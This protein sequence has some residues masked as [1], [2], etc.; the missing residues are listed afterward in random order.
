MSRKAAAAEEQQKQ[1]VLEAKRKREQAFQ[2][3]KVG[4]RQRSGR[5]DADA[6]CL[7]CCCC[8][9]CPVPGAVTC[10]ARC[11]FGPAVPHCVAI[12]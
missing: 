2:A 5:T 6:A 11:P 8:S 7:Q 4:V 3:P 9:S 10:P 1:R 12:A